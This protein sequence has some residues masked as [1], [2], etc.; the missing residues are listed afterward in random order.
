MDHTP[1]CQYWAVWALAN[2]TRVYCKLGIHQDV[3]GPCKLF[4]S[5]ASFVFS[6][7]VLSAA[8]RGKRIRSVGGVD[9]ADKQRQGASVRQDRSGGIP[10]VPPTQFTSDAG[11]EL[12]WL[13]GVKCHQE[14]DFGFVH[15]ECKHKDP[16]YQRLIAIVK[17]GHGFIPIS[18]FFSIFF[19]RPEKK[20]ISAKCLWI[21][22]FVIFC[23]R[24]K[25]SFLQQLWLY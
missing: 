19:S 20:R 25:N 10:R 15:N 12:G 11:R 2:L 22:F 21:G 5:L 6:W 1:E 18:H 3:Y 8:K 13:G 9:C 4:F 17:R 23:F 14:M 16:F 7:K 24:K